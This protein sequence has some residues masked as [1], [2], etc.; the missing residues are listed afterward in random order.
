M[1]WR[2]REPGDGWPHPRR[3][4]DRVRHQGADP[5]RRAGEPA[6]MDGAGAPRAVRRPVV[7][8][9]QR[10]GRFGVRAQHGRA[11][12]R[13]LE[14]RA[15]ARRRRG[16]SAADRLANPGA[17]PR[18]GRAG[19]RQGGRGRPLP[20]PRR[21]RTADRSA[22]PRGVPLP[23]A[24]EG[25]RDRRRP[26]RHP[27]RGPDDPRARH[28]SLLLRGPGR[29]RLARQLPLHPGLR[30]AGTGSAESTARAGRGSGR[31]GLFAG[32]AGLG[33]ARPPGG[34]ARR[35]GA[36]G[37]RRSRSRAPSVRARRRRCTS[38]C[39]P[40]TS[41]ATIATRSRTCSTA[42][43]PER[44]GS[45]RAA[46]TTSCR[47]AWRRRSWCSRGA[48]TGDRSGPAPPEMWAASVEMLAKEIVP[49][50]DGRFRTIAEPGA[51]AVVGPAFDAVIAIDAAF[52]E[53]GVFGAV[54]IQSAFLLDVIE[55]ALKARVRP[56][57]RAA[58]AR[59]PRLGPLRTR[60]HAG[61][62][63]L[64]R[65]EPPLQRV[66]A[67]EGPPARGRRGQGRRRLGELAQPD[68]PALLGAV[69]AASASLSLTSASRWLAPDGGSRVRGEYDDDLD[70]RGRARRHRGEVGWS[71]V[72]TLCPRAGN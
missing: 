63:G 3:R 11:G 30:E 23:R 38:T 37:W 60:L 44:G 5:S 48:W 4:P 46:S 27:A 51:R 29:A 24:R 28:R 33:R 45:C 41:A 68:G 40:A 7:D 55:T 18:R 12:P 15:G 35:A 61:G 39:P 25:R 42:T 32:H 36:G 22:R 9:A 67:V 64:A 57:L 10:R 71:A 59:V 16:R 21:Q 49:L 62:E 58:P 43:A 72:S 20:R 19:A 70:A 1:K 66:P 54:G 6:G 14:G 47:S 65:G 53:P 2:T 34:A 26:A 13:G 52:S 69:P 17:L 31:G 8:G 56:S 50:I